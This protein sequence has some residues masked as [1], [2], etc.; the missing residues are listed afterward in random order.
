MNPVCYFL[1]RWSMRV[2]SKLW[3]RA[4]LHGADRVPSEGGVVIVGNHTSH[5]D[6]PLIGAFF[7]RWTHFLARSTLGK[8]GLAYRFL[9]ALGTVFIDRD[10][11]TR[12]SMQ[13]A[14]DLL[15]AGGMVLMFPEGTRSRDGRVHDFKRGVELMVRRSGASVLPIGIQGA[16]ASM[17]RGRAFPRPRKIRIRVGELVSADEF[18]KPGGL[19]RVRG[20]VAELARAELAES[21][22]DT[23]TETEHGATAG[24]EADAAPHVRR[25]SDGPT[26]ASNH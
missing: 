25:R 8:R 11:P 15:S 13:E 5:L 10:A 19:E 17:P 24:P 22:R 21:S 14:I 16:F 26:A 1:A 23:K 12:S 6:P 7:P 3:M 9:R 18:R 4:S 20:M 2:F